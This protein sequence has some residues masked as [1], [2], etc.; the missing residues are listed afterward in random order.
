MKKIVVGITGSFG[1]GKSSVASMFKRMG[2]Q[3]ID[4][5]KIAHKVILRGEPA[6]KKIVRIFGADILSKNKEI[7]RGKL[8]ECVFGSRDLLRRLNSIIHPQVIAVICR[9]IAKSRKIA[10]CLDVPLLIEADLVKLVDKL[11]VVTVSREKQIARIKKKTHLAKSDILK[12]I[13]AQM[14]LSDK[15]RMADFV[16]DNNG[17]IRQTEKQVEKTWGLLWK[18]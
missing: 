11:I 17:T 2:A 8:A 12:R 15:V 9:A 5:D 3:V 14:P 18:N 10:V 7:D 1:S 6:Y 4:A 16:I 13:R